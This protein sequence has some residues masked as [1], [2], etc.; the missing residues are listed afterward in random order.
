MSNNS[1]FLFHFSAA[2]KGK[3]PIS[4]REVA[5][6]MSVFI[7]SRFNPNYYIKSRLKNNDGGKVW[8]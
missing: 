6:Q 8:D 5:V 1:S 2:F 7:I 4:S 3:I